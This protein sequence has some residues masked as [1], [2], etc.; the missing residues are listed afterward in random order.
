[1][2]PIFLKQTTRLKKKALPIGCFFQAISIGE[3]H[4]MPNSMAYRTAPTINLALSILPLCDVT[5]GQEAHDQ[6]DDDNAETV[7]Q[8]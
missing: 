3:K 6:A 4:V 1:M 2:A 7:N 8:A 5:G